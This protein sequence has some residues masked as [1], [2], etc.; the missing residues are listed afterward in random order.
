MSNLKFNDQ[1]VIEGVTK[2]LEGMDVD[3]RNE[4]FADTPKRVMKGFREICK[5][6]YEKDAALDSFTKAIFSSNNDEMVVMKNIEVSSICPHHL[7]P[8][9]VTAS[10]AYIP[11][12][13]VVGLSKLVRITEMICA[14]LVLQEDA[15]T[16][17]ADVLMDKLGAEGSAVYIQ[18]LHGCMMHRGVKKS[19]AVTITSALRGAFKED[20]KTRSEFFDLVRS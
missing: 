13:K 5:G 10:V 18:G 15:T 9:M 19:N 20:A 3:L 12:G 6:L 4:N 1:L 7:L 11:K 14:Q 17:I 8:V 16:E 2:I